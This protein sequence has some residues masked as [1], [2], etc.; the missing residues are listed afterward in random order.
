M[1]FNFIPVTLEQKSLFDSFL[2]IKDSIISVNDFATIYCWNIS[3]MAQFVIVDDVLI[4]SNVYLGTK[5]YYCPMTKNCKQCIRKYVEKIIDIEKDND[6]F[7]AQITD[8]EIDSFKDI[9][10]FEF[11]YDRNFSDYIYLAKDLIELKGKK[12]HGKRNHI[13]KFIGSYNYIFRDYKDSDFEGCMNLF[14]NW[15]IGNMEGEISEKLALTLALKN[16]KNLNLKC[17]VIEIDGKISAYSVVSI[18][19]NGK[20]GNVLF[21]K[22][23]TKYEG[24]FPAI[25][26][27]CAKEYLSQVEYINRQEDMGFEGLRKSKLSYNPVQILHKYKLIRKK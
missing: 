14:D 11:T 12:F 8:D 10:G 6:F 13:N 26:N 7:I 15:L 5:V 1:E 20:A 9:E 17:G 23:D 3:D 24:I 27:F 19:P 21:E 18:L 4:L 22:G 16:L 25:N 2:S